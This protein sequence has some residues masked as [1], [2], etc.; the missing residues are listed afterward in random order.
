[1]QDRTHWKDLGPRPQGILR[2][3]VPACRVLSAH[4]PALQ[5]VRSRW[6]SAPLPSKGVR[7]HDTSL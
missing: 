6:V 7:A 5:D 2:G 3:V 1:M 4:I